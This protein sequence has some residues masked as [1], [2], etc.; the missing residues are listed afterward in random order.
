MLY[1]FILKELNKKKIFEIAMRSKD[2]TKIIK[3]C[4]IM[5]ESKQ[6]LEMIAMPLRSPYKT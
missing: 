3:T 2:K 1:I 4:L 5:R 6:C